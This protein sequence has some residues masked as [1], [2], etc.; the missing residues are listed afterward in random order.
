MEV[1]DMCTDIHVFIQYRLY[2]G[3]GICLFRFPIPTSA[4]IIYI[5]TVFLF[6]L[7]SS[8]TKEGGVAQPA[9]AGASAEGG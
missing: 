5:L 7:H 3:T 6:L 9:G 8:V 1:T 2:D 4:S